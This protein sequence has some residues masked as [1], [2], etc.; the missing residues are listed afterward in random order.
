MREMDVREPNAVLRFLAVFAV[1][2]VVTAP[3]AVFL[4]VMVLVVDD[5]VI[6]PTATLATAAIASLV[7]SWAA[8]SLATNEKR[9]H[10]AA[11][12]V[13]NLLWGVVPAVVAFF[14][15]SSLDRSVVLI[16][17][18]IVY[19]ALTGTVLATRHLSGEATA[20]ED[21]KLTVS[22]LVGTVVGVGVVIFIASLF[23][24]TGA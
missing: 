19:T 18:V 23:G 22:W 13:R 16:A 7:A 12:A 10:L 24:L 14:L 5:Q 4:F 8:S 17:A 6:F 3:I 15:G 1:T 2:V 9:T 20:A 11:V 21:G